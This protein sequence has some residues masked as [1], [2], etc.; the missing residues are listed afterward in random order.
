MKSNIVLQLITIFLFSYSS[1]LF[2]KL[3]ITFTSTTTSITTNLPYSFLAR[4]TQPAK[5]SDVNHRNWPADDGKI[6]QRYLSARDLSRFASLSV[7]WWISK[8]PH[9]W[10]SN[11]WYCQRWVVYLP[12]L[13]HICAVYKNTYF[14]LYLALQIWMTFVFCLRILG[15]T[16]FIIFN[17]SNTYSTLLTLLQLSLIDFFITTDFMFSPVLFLLFPDP[18]NSL[19]LILNCQDF[20]QLCLKNFRDL[21]AL[22]LG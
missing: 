13:Y 15:Q 16:R 4:T 7:L 21:L 22:R 19:E 17:F 3:S 1:L 6:W 9:L 8:P 5:Q 14:K 2:S 11:T 12:K 20:S 18:F 10:Q